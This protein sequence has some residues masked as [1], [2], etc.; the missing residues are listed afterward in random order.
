MVHQLCNIKV[1]LP[2]ATSVQNHSQQLKPEHIF[3]SCVKFEVK[4][5]GCS[6]Y[7]PLSRLKALGC[8]INSVLTLP[9]HL[10]QVNFPDRSS[11]SN[12]YSSSA[13]LAATFSF[14]FFFDSAIWLWKRKLS[15]SG[16]AASK[17][18]SQGHS[19]PSS[20]IFLYNGVCL[21]AH[22]CVLPFSLICHF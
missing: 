21:S 16:P 13:L 5:S 11:P 20:L 22:K 8:N 14:T 1:G 6:L 10:P 17:L 4:L 15:R 19:S 9:P 3:F 2:T 12:K 18:F 7:L